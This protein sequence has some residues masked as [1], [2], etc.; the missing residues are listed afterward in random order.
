MDSASAI[1]STR[2]SLPAINSWTSMSC[3]VWKATKKRKNRLQKAQKMQGPRRCHL[4]DLRGS[5]VDRLVPFRF[6][7]EH[8]LH[9]LQWRSTPLENIRTP[10]GKPRPLDRAALEGLK[11]AIASS[12]GDDSEYAYL[13][14]VGTRLARISPDLNARNYGYQNLR[15]LVEASGIAD[16]KTKTVE[17]KPSVS[18]VRLKESYEGVRLS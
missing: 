7:S 16:L 9:R 8:P 6:R 18:F 12:I 17:G 13:A 1:Q 3:P 2:S 5:I 4:E 14:E 10:F 15:G 11:K